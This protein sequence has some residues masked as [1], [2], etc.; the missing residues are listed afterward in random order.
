MVEM[1]ILNDKN[2]VNLRGSSKNKFAFSDHTFTRLAAGRWQDSMS[3]G[4]KSSHIDFLF[5]FGQCGENCK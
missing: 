1:D 3:P 2:L 5:I 4:Q